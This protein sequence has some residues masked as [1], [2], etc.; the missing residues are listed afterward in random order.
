[1][2]SVKILHTADLHLGSFRTGVKYGKGEIENTFLRIINLCKD[3]KV[4]F[5]LIA[6]DLFDTPFVPAED[7]AR[8]ISAIRQIPDTIVAISPGNHDCACPGSVYLKYTFPENTVIFS[9]FM[10]YADFPEKGV[11]LWGAGFTDRFENFALLKKPDDLDPRLINICVLHGDVVSDSSASTYNPVT[12]SAIEGCGF[13][14]IA[15]GH[16]HKPT[17]IQKTVGTSFAYCGC[18]DPMGFD[19][20]GAR[21]VYMGTISKD[22]CSLG[23]VPTA[24][25]QYVVDN[26]NIDG[27]EN[28]VEAAEIVLEHIKSTYG[29]DFKNNLYRISLTGSISAEAS[30]SAAL[31]QSVLSNSLDYVEVFDRCDSDIEALIKLKDESS[32]R[33]L[34]VKKLLEKLDTATAEEKQTYK[35]ALKIGIRAFGKGV[36]LDDN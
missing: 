35:N 26:V 21:G 30:V 22:G 13:D 3:E 34:F 9:S 5:L 14:Y 16:I 10:E 36:K 6:G 20:V 31:V 11:R 7:A 19:E 28:S 8:I 27:C 29:E 18:P 4:D 2:N 25:R 23:F 32:L 1:M 12:P 24:S 17:D 33:G 15:L